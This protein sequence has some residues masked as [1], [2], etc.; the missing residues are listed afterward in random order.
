MLHHLPPQSL[1]LSN[2][3]L[4][5]GVKFEFI[6]HHERIVREMLDELSS[7][8]DL[9]FPEI[10]AAISGSRKFRLITDAR[11]D[12]LGVVVEQQQPDGS[13]RS[14]RYFS[15]TTLDRSISELECAAVVKAIRRNRK[16]F[17]GIPFEVETDHEPLQNLA[18]LSNK[19]NRV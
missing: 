13:I 7:P 16:M 10:E 1:N 18:S 6:P 8:N 14:L 15:K 11:A 2:S 17:Y 4:R 19:S 5:K 9:A 12:G 3:L